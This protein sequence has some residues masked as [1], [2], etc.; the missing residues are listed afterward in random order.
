MNTRVSVVI[1]CYNVEKTIDRAVASV[2]AQSTIPDEVLCV[3]DGSTDSTGMRLQALQS[4]FECLNIQIITS[5]DQR[6]AA[7]ARN[8]G[9]NVAKGDYIAFLDADDTWHP[10]K[11]FLQIGFMNSVDDAVI[12]GHRVGSPCS[13]SSDVASTQASF[14]ALT[15]RQILLS[16][17]LL[18]PSVVIRNTTSH[19]FDESMVRCEDYLLWC[20]MLATG[21]KAFWSPAS[22]ASVYKHFYGEGGLSGNIL[23]MAKWEVIMY[24]RLSQSGFI[25]KGVFAALSV[26]LSAKVIRRLSINYLRRGA[27]TCSPI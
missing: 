10:N 15:Y 11:L 1:P 7:R 25:S 21:C 23:S 12:T 24:T 14:Q 2:A 19:R 16:N 5:A 27:I 6:G 20:Q 18:T 26:W 17:R 13:E 3:D 4:R 22:L 9:W 8:T